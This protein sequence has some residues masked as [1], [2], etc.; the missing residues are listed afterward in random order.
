MRR[1]DKSVLEADPG[2]SVIL[3]WLEAALAAVEPESLTGE[4]LAHWEGKQVAVV[5][6]GK[7]APAMTRGAVSVADVVSGISVSDHA[8]TGMDRIVSLIGDHP[9][10][11]ARSLEAGAAV[12]EFVGSV[13]EDMDL[14]ALISGGG[15]ALCEHPR[16]GVGEQYLAMVN[17]HLVTGGADIAEINLVR[18]HLSSIKCG[19]L[20][21]IARRPIDTLVISDVPGTDPGLVASGPTAWKPPQASKA[22]EIMTRHGIEVSDQVWAAM[23]SDLGR[24]HAG[25]VT[26]LADGFDAARA[27]ADSVE[28]PVSIS[29]EW[30]AGEV[31]QC[32]S[33]FFDSAGPGVT[34]AVGEPSLRVGGP[35]RGGRNTHAA[36]LAAGR[37][38]GNDSVFVSFATDGVDGAS[39]AS[40]AVVDGST[41]DR[42]GEPMAALLAFDSASYLDACGDLLCCPPTGTNVSD[43]WILWNRSPNTT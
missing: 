10:P 11:A 5:A 20:C 26:L 25:E 33:D 39:G 6:I 9:V 23:S 42:G 17:Q 29:P 4:A 2:R 14:I 43:I 3:R 12:V 22:R 19:G 36:L 13:P 24:V 37:L 38:R 16:R 30:L 31:A 28:G 7:A 18:S 1:F 8:E 40:G 32:L 21:R 35:G 34:V 15:S 41:I 27:V